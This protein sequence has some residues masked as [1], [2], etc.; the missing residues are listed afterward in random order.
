MLF[1]AEP[2][3][4]YKEGF[5]AGTR[6]S[7]AEG[8]ELYIN[9]GTISKDFEGFL[10]ILR[11]ASD[12]IKVPPERV[13]MSDY[14]LIDGDEYIG[15]LCE[16]GST[17]ATAGIAVQWLSA[18]PQLRQYFGELRI[19]PIIRCQYQVSTRNSPWV[20]AIHR[21]PTAPPRFSPARKQTSGSQISIQ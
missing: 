21:L 5:I 7:Q 17:G 20:D 18:T 13:S 9:L 11:D 2:S 12:D 10:Q 1:L 4:A 6:E 16:R 3:L 14:W 15:R 19:L 8:L